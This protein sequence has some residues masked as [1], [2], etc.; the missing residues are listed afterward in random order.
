MAFLTHREAEE[1]FACIL[2]LYLQFE[3]DKSK[4]M[5]MKTPDNIAIAEV[6][7]RASDRDKETR[8]QCGHCVTPSL[9]TEF[10]LVCASC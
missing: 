8:E 6:I 4:H 10:K 9:V 1:E 2:G 7:G 5:P 3:A